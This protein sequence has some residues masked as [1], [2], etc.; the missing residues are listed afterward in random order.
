MDQN[1]IAPWGMSRLVP[2]SPPDEVPAVTA[3]LDTASQTARYL[4]AA[5]KPVE[6]DLESAGRCAPP[7]TRSESQGDVS[8]DDGEPDEGSAY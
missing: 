3:E 1:P 7:G 4:D 2:S 5:G 8:S 6:F